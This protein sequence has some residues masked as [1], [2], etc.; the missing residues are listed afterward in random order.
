MTTASPARRGYQIGYR[1]NEVN[2]C[3]GCGQ[4]QWQIGRITAEC[5]FCATTVPIL[6]GGATGHGIIWRSKTR[7]DREA[8]AA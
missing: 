4:S 5:A 2:H 3:P 1:L 6:A 8:Q 7:R